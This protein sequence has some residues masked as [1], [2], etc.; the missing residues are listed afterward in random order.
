MLAMW[1]WSMIVDVCVEVMG[2]GLVVVVGGGGCVAV[3]VKKPRSGLR[4][5]C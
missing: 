1:W 5:K 3:V 4:D 2:E